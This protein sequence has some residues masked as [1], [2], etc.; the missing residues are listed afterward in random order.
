[1]EQLKETQENGKDKQPVFI[2]RYKSGDNVTNYLVLTIF[3]EVNKHIYMKT[4][5]QES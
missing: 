5:F 2:M 4:C 3:S 1:M